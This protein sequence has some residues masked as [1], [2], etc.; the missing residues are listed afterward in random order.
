MRDDFVTSY[1]QY[2]ANTEPPVFFH[3]WCI[4]SAL[5]A[6]LARDVV[7]ELGDFKIY[8]NMYSMLI[9]VPGTRKSTAI[10]LA[11][12]LL[13]KAGF[14]SFSADKSSKE[15]FLIDL[16][17]D[18]NIAEEALDLISEN[19]WGEESDSRISEMFIACDEFNNFIGNG[20]LE[21]ISL[22]GELWDYE[23]IYSNRIKNGKSVVVP[24]PTINILGGNTPTGFSLAFP[25]QAIGQG[26]FSRLILVYSDPSP[27][28]ITFPEKSNDD[29]TK[30]MVDQLLAIKSCATS[31]R[32]NIT[33][34]AKSLLDKIYQSDN[35]MDDIRFEHYYNRRFTHLVKLALICCLSRVSLE[36]NEEDVVVANTILT[37]TEKFMP[38]ALG[39]FG[40]AKH[41]K[42]VHKIISALEASY[43]VM[44][45]SD[46]WKAVA[47]DLD[48][49]GELSSIMGGLLMANKVLKAEG[50]FLPKRQLLEAQYDDMVDYSFLS[51]EEIG[52]HAA[53]ERRSSKL[54]LVN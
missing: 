39:E 27:R 49:P 11:K 21:F 26:F 50:G 35:R 38:K 30:Y 36:L 6:Y 24:N 5:G 13:Q 4:L 40:E 34:S 7:F 17:D 1:L 18:G 8:P 2:R 19:L 12:K 44:D 16:A 14:D 28:R 47:Q 15:K 9:G 42:V 54:Q 3:R 29:D 25:S 52:E 23:G 43:K 51:D 46:I 20:N 22:L 37:H 45:M 32:L 53:E 31:G 48:K 41:A 10:K 33:D